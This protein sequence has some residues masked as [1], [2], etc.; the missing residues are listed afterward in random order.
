MTKEIL[1]F[2]FEAYNFGTIFKYDP[3]QPH[4]L[5]RGITESFDYKC[6]DVI[7]QYPSHSSA[8]TNTFLLYDLPDNKNFKFFGVR[9]FFF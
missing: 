5:F 6:R 2:C 8:V 7:T 4:P 3:N 1:P 9:N